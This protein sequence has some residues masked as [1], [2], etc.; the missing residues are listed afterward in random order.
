MSSWTYINANIHISRVK[1]PFIVKVYNLPKGIDDDEYDDFCNHYK[2]F[3]YKLVDE[4]GSKTLIKDYTEK[5]DEFIYSLPTLS[6]S[7]GECEVVVGHCPK[8]KKLWGME[9]NWSQTRDLDIVGEK[10]VSEIY[11]DDVSEEN[12]ESIWETADGDNF[13]IFLYGA[14]RDRTYADTEKELIQYLKTLYK[15]FE[16]EFNGIEICL[17][18]SITEA[19][20]TLDNTMRNLKE[21]VE[22]LKFAITHKEYFEDKDDEWK[23]KISHRT[24]KVEIGRWK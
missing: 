17:K 1:K 3:K 12:I 5:V 24:K 15:Y 2:N 14:M 23:Y 11:E 8:L 6:G 7:E 18:D 13:R 22:K 9:A 10:L 21:G 4:D 16:I 19:R 20:I